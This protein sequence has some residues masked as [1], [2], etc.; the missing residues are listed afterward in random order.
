M[1]QPLLITK[2]K[3]E[4][5]L[6]VAIGYNERDFDRFIRE[7]QEFDFKPLVCE[8][9]YYD[10][11]KNKDQDPFDKIVVGQEYEFENKTHYHQ[12]VELV[13][14]YFTYARFVLNSGA[15]NTS[16]GLVTKKTPQ[17]DPL[18]Y[19]EKKDIYYANRQNANKVFEDVKKYMDRK[20][21]NYKD[22]NDCSDSIIGDDIVIRAMKW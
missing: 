15:V 8:D 5:F 6:Q 19:S 9:F 3:V 4:Q 22:C 2:S 14:S 12:G 21:I 13:I 11:L 16:H 7:A 20:K 18:P 17:S 1:M 10:M